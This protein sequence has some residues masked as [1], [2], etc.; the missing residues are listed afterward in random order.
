MP[1]P[2]VWG[3]LHLLPGLDA[4][5]HRDDERVE[6]PGREEDAVAGKRA[7]EEE[8]E[9]VT[10]SCVLDAFDIAAPRCKCAGS[11]KMFS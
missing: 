11:A 9:A 8:L 6:R 4:S 2:K 3:H 10:R 7:E 5:R 1:R